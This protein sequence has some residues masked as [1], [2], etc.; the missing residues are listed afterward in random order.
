MAALDTSADTIFDTLLVF[1]A[2]SY[3]TWPESICPIP[4]P[5]FKDEGDFLLIFF[6]DF[7]GSVCFFRVLFVFDFRTGFAPLEPAPLRW[8]FKPFAA[9]LANH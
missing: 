6:I 8:D 7:L 4:A 1:R 3:A 9:V 5:A 2:H